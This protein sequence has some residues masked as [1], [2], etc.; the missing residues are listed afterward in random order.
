MVFGLGWFQICLQ[1]LRH[2]RF[3]SLLFRLQQFFRRLFYS[4]RVVAH[5][6]TSVQE[7]VSP[8]IASPVF[9]NP[10][11]VIVK[12]TRYEHSCEL[13]I[14]RNL[15]CLFWIRLSIVPFARNMICMLERV[16]TLVWRLVFRRI[17]WLLSL[18]VLDTL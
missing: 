5:F 12:M 8:S 7:A 18:H 1:M 9:P 3:R 10:R 13:F 4:L 17:F 16:E 2:S 6:P 15:S 14:L 11:Q